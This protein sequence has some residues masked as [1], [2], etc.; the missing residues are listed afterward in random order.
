MEPL[1]ILLGILAVVWVLA[2]PILLIAQWSRT[3]RLK[4]DVDDLRLRLA[5]AIRDVRVGAP[6]AAGQEEG[7]SSSKSRLP[8][9]SGP[10]SRRCRRRVAPPRPPARPGVRPQPA[11]KLAS[12]AAAQATPSDEKEAHD[13][14]EAPQGISLRGNP[15]RPL[16]HLG[17]ALAVVIG[18]GFFL[19]YAIENR[20][21]DETGRA[22]P[23]AGRRDGGVRRRRVCDAQGLSRTLI[24]GSSARCSACSI[25]HCFRR[26]A[27]IT[28]SQ[29]RRCLS[30]A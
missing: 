4:Q 22:A 12:I 6:R 9:R 14:A 26:L 13:E 20:W 7:A 19:K 24:R 25:S 10:P 8:F 3:S 5:K 23:R 1:L 17:P 27:G 29:S 28:C 18:V 21:I 11:E 15:C 16:A 2:G 30:S